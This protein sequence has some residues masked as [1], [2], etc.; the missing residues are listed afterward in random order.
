[1]NRQIWLFVLLT[2]SM[3]WAGCGKGSDL[4]LVPVTGELTFDGNPP[5][6]GGS[7]NFMLVKG[8]GI[9]GLPDRP[10]RANFGT[11]GKFE[12]SSFKKGDGLLPGKYTANVICFVGTPSEADP[13]SYERLSRVPRDYHPELVVEEDGGPRHVK[14]D[15][16]PKKD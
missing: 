8:S 5:P 3:A 1:M 6:A 9:S 16:P 7:I 2:G 11:D 4:P 12:V 14:Y 15:V 13:S 10:G